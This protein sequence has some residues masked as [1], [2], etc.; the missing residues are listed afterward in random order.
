MQSHQDHIAKKGNRSPFPYALVHTPV[1]IPEAMKIPAAKA[2]ADK[3]RDKLKNLQAWDESKVRDKVNVIREAQ[4]KKT[5]VHFV[6]LM[7][8]CRLENSE[9]AGHTHKITEDESCFVE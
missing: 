9:L 3:E 5:S 4:G 2:A 8:L 7:N 6:M 1:S